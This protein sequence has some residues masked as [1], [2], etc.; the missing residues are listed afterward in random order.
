MKFINVWVA[1]QIKTPT[2]LINFE[3]DLIDTVYLID[4]E[5]KLSINTSAN[6]D[7]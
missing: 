6:S 2:K 1:L 7:K 4:Y 5:Y 3:I